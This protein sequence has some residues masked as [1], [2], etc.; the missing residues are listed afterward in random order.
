MIELYFHSDNLAKHGVTPEEVEACFS[1]SRRLLRK[2]GD[3]YL[4][5]AKTDGG[6]LLQI[7][8]RKKG[9]NTY[10]VFHAMPAKLFER[11]HYQSRG[12]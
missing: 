4:L 11:R 6:R 9:R 12:K 5:V 2:S 3:C 10:F 8:Y 7:G 1:D